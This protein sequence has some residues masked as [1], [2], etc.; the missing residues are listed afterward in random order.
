MYIRMS[1]NSIKQE[2]YDVLSG[3]IKIRNGEPLQTIACYL[4][5]SQETSVIAKNAKQFKREEAQR[6]KAL[7][8]VIGKPSVLCLLHNFYFVIPISYPDSYREEIR[9]SFTEGLIAPRLIR[10]IDHEVIVSSF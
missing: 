7:N 10:R 2:L 9:C 4:R 3:K 1:N 6:L 5:T 8:Y